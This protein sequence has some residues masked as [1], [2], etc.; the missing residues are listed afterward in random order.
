[1]DYTVWHQI[2][3]GNIFHRIT[4]FAETI[5][6]RSQVGFFFISLLF[7]SLFPLNF[8]I[9]I[10]SDLIIPEHL[11]AFSFCSRDTAYALLS[12]EEVLGSVVS[13]EVLDLLAVDSKTGYARQH[14]HRQ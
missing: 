7:Y 3:E 12:S 6:R 13:V 4:C 11:G 1:M 5:F 10:P 9:I 14:W 8:P 2:F